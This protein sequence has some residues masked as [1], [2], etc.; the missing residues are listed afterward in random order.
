MLRG[1]RRG[2]SASN[3]ATRVRIRAGL[4]V[5]AVALTALLAV[6]VAQAATTKASVS[7]ATPKRAAALKSG[8]TVKVTATGRTTV[9]LGGDLVASAAVKFTKKGTK[10]VR[11]PLSGTG[12]T[13]LGACG[14]V[15]ATVSVNATYVVKG[16]TKK[17][18]GSAKAKWKGGA[19]AKVTVANADRCDPVGYGQCLTPFPSDFYT[20]A[21]RKTQTGVRVNL[22]RDAMPANKDGVHMDPAEWNRND[23]FSVGAP[24]N[25]QIAGLDTKAAF[26]ANKIVPVTDMAQYAR[27]D[28]PVVLIDAATGKRFPIWAEMDAN[29]ATDADRLMEIHP[30]KALEPGHHYVV[31]IRKLKTVA[32]KAIA[33]TPAFKAFRDRKFTANKAVEKRRPALE[34]DF[35]VL[36]AAGIARKDLTLAW[37]FTVASTENTTERMLSIRDD[38]FKQLG[39]TNLA[40]ATVQGTSPQF[41]I[42]SV[43]NFANSDAPDPLQPGQ[44]RSARG[45]RR[46]AGTVRVPCYLTSDKCAPEGSFNYGANGLPAQ[47]P[48]NFIDAKIRCIIPR[49]SENGP[50]ATGTRP[51]IYGHGLFGTAEQGWRGNKIDYAFES[52]LTICAAEFAGMADEDVNPSTIKIIQD[53]SLFKNMAD[54]IQQGLLDFTYVGR[55]MVNAGGLGTSPAF[56]DGD[57][58]TAGGSVFAADKQ[59]GY[60]GISEGGILGGALTAIGPDAINTVLNVPGMSYATL[61]PRSTDFA[62]FAI[63]LY[64][65]Y[66]N[67]RERPNVFTLMQMLWDRGEAAGYVH[68]MTDDPLPNTPK[69]RILM[70]EAFGDHQVA[71]VTAEAQARTLGLSVRGPV[72][73][74]GRS[75]DVKPF[76]DIPVMGALPF[77]GSGITLWDSGPTRITGS[78]EGQDEKLFGTDAPPTDNTAPLSGSD[79]EVKDGVYKPLVRG[80]GDDPHG[81]PGASVPARLQLGAFLNTG[82]VI[83]TCDAGKPC[84][85]GGWTGP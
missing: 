7:V 26:A 1:P 25:V 74:P 46:V 8:V 38:A 65:S 40:D 43:M 54:R 45:A 5:P 9:Q 72:V 19:C 58:T 17:T 59:L 28:Q 11:L 70:Q 42:E 3:A 49:A 18:K 84:F 14:N 63:L 6:P 47:K 57:G 85:D 15:K 62:E 2:T 68:N 10:T 29:A 52:G 66:P 23:G 61:L 24:I 69:H 51:V 73:S 71:N 21:D 33:P 30:S 32:G 22:K 4:I 44:E 81:E 53:L 20:V 55:A 35:A 67:Q 13:K 50:I 75:T 78:V 60:F 82:T 76:W 83:E 12:V 36:A 31:A 79:G 34:D 16:K 27:K 56:Q 77:N 48:G 41:T 39:D 64:P 80:N 37:D